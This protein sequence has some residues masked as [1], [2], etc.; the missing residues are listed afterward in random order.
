[1]GYFHVINLNI[2]TVIKLSASAPAPGFPML[3]RKVIMITI[4]NN[5]SGEKEIDIINNFTTLC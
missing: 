2:H 4:P 3:K 1:M 5:V